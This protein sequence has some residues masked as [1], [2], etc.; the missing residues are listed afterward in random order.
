MEDKF[1]SCPDVDC[2]GSDAEWEQDDIDEG[3]KFCQY[4]GKELVEISSAAE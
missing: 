3:I 4:C 1:Y 2:Q